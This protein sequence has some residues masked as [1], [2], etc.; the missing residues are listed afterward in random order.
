MALTASVGRYLD[1]RRRKS[2]DCSKIIWILASNALDPV[3]T[4]FYKNNSTNS[5]I[6]DPCVIEDQLQP[7]LLGAMKSKFGVRLFL[8]I[9]TPLTYSLLSS[10][11]LDGYQQ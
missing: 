1:R 3:I 2:I 11:Y 5:P 9:K 8:K 6:A 4:D 7:R 10:R